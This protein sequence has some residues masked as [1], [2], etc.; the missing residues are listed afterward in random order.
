MIHASFTVFGTAAVHYA[1]VAQQEV[2]KRTSELV[3]RDGAAAHKFTFVSAKLLHDCSRQGGEK[4]HFS[5]SF[6][7]GGCDKVSWLHSMNNIKITPP[8]ILRGS[9]S[10]TLAFASQ[11]TYRLVEV[12]C[13]RPVSF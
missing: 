11:E 13:Y 3:G 12:S 6:L 9:F 2:A 8:K 7:L 5:E 10:P 4:K 1:R